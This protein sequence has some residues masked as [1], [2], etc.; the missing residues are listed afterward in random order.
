MPIRPIVPSFLLPLLLSTALLGQDSELPLGLNL[1]TAD[2]LQGWQPAIRFTHRFAEPARGNSKDFY[3]LDGG[4]FAGLGFDL[5]IAAIPGLN[6]QVY[7]TSD[8]KTVILALQERLLDRPHIRMAVGGNASMK[9]SS[10]PPT[11]SE[12]WASPA[13]PCNYPRNS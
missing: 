4:N 5:G 7:R 3:G 9:R 13:R 10:A 8:G 12:P 11:P 1:P 2:H 6:A